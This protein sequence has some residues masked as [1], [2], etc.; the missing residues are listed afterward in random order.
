MAETLTNVTSVDDGQQVK[1][2]IQ[3]EI[4]T[5]KNDIVSLYIPN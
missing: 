4:K 3:N 5:F 2:Q 1:H